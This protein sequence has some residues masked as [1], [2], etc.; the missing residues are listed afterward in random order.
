[1]TGKCT[2][3]VCKDG[4]T[5]TEGCGIIKAV[6]KVNRGRGFLA[7]LNT[8][9]KGHETKL[10]KAGDVEWFLTQLAVQL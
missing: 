7:C 1:M 3:L 10:A 6:E 4:N 8:R 2:E 5:E 9:T